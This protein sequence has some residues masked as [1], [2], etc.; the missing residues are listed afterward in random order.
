MGL[1]RTEMGVMAKKRG[2]V[3]IWELAD[4]KNY[5]SDDGDCLIGLV[6]PSSAALAPRRR[7]PP[8]RTRGYAAAAPLLG[9]LRSRPARSAVGRQRSFSSTLAG[10]GGGVS[11]MKR[12]DVL[13]T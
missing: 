11:H 12:K 5:A 4:E 3:V 10:E 8:G 13:T 1:E 7:W 9:E 2:A 6:P